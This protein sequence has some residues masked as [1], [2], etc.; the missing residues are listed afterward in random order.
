MHVYNNNNNNIYY[1]LC[2]VICSLF[3]KL[4]GSTVSI[5]VSATDK[6]SIAPDDVT[7]YDEICGP[8]ILTEDYAAKSSTSQ[9][10]VY[11]P[12]DCKNQL[13]IDY[14]SE[15]KLAI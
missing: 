5:P 15:L 2:T 13:I 10:G 1:S 12:I 11:T 6:D 7:V 9:P 4:Q 3:T 8:V 14:T